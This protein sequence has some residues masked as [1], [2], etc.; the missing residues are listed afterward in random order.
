MPRNK[1]NNKEKNGGPSEPTNTLEDKLQTILNKLSGI[2]LKLD[3][4][5]KR[6]NKLEAN[7]ASQPALSLVL[8]EHCSKPLNKGKGK[9]A[10]ILLQL[11]NLLKTEKS[12]DQLKNVNTTYPSQPLQP[13]NRWR[14]EKISTF[15]GN[16]KIVKS[17]INYL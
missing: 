6:I 9:S 15:N 1:P 3:N 16:P 4:H 10:T 17:F 12:D 13:N 8:P 5:D 14:P 7:Q 11:G 2:E